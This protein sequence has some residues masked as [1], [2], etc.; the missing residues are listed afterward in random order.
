M[1]TRAVRTHCRDYIALL[2][3]EHLRILQKKL[4]DKTLAVSN[5]SSQNLVNMEMFCIV[6]LMSS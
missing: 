6:I 5:V 3:G 2:D 4:E 1:E